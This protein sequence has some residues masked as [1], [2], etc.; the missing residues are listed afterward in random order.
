MDIFYTALLVGTIQCRFMKKSVNGLALHT[1]RGGQTVKALRGPDFY[2]QIGR[3]GGE[4]T[5]KKYGSEFY[6]EIGRKGGASTRTDKK[7]APVEK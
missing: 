7:K 5:K 2:S 6:A 4:S 3:R 1:I